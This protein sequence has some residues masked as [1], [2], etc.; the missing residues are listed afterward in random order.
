M[1]AA[2]TSENSQVWVIGGF[3]EWKIVEL[4]QKLN[5]AIRALEE[6]ANTKIVNS[7]MELARK[8]LGK[9]D[10]EYGARKFLALDP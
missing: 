1:D 5:V 3:Q 9:I 8:A 4:R 6:I 2:D 10:A 7:Q